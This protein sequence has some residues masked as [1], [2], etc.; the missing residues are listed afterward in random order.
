MLQVA[1]LLYNSLLH[2]YL[3]EIMHISSPG[4]LGPSISHVLAGTSIQC[5]LQFH[6]IAYVANWICVS[7]SEGWF[8][9]LLEWV[10]HLNAGYSALASDHSMLSHR[11]FFNHLANWMN[12]L[13]HVHT[14]IL[15]VNHV[16]KQESKFL[17]CFK[18]IAFNA[19]NLL[20]F[21]QQ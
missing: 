15:Y 5:Q 9:S 11:K 17:K 10:F 4:Q 2:Y 8:I 14:C 1:V 7:S 6:W 20:L 12:H 13:Q 3:W 19:V 16:P 18:A 21:I